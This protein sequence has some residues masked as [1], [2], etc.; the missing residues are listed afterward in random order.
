M[1]QSQ[2]FVPRGRFFGLSKTVDF[3]T[4]TT[5]VPEFPLS[6]ELNQP[7]CVCTE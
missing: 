4:R 5:A 7:A 3:A 1:L 2:Y 6:S